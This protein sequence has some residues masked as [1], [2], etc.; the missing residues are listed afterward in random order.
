MAKG[1]K[2]STQLTFMTKDRR[3]F[4]ALAKTGRATAEQTSKYYNT[5]EKRLRR[6]IKEGYLKK[7][8]I[9]V[10]G[11]KGKKATYCFRLTDQGK[12][13]VKENLATVDCLYK[14]TTKGTPHDV[15]LFEKYSNLT[16]Y[17]QDIALT[18]NDVVK[19]WGK[20]KGTSPPDLVVPSF[21]TT[22]E[23]TNITR[24]VEM[25][26]IEITTK[27]YTQKDIDAKEAYVK[28]LIGKEVSVDYDKAN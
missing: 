21:K 26:V 9:M 12:K 25:K 4:Q 1:R 20:L 6:F 13:W 24:T 3:L 27:T 18:E 10:D 17:E 2:K 23:I 11:K 15:K 22:S 7:E 5:K 16:E 28:E 19:R 14:P 8:P